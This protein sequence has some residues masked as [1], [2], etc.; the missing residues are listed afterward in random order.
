METKYIGE[1]IFQDTTKPFIAFEKALKEGQIIKC[2]SDPLIDVENLF[3]TACPC[4]S[5]HENELDWALFFVTNI[6]LLDSE[7][8]TY[9]YECHSFAYVEE[10]GHKLLDLFH[11]V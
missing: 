9:P 4:H 10:N 1:I 6:Q 11:C 7:E 5:R 2:I 3:D 8:L